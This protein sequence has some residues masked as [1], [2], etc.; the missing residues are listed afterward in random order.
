MSEY[1]V[2][3]FRAIDRPVTAENLEF[4]EEQSSRAEIT[5]WSFDNVYNYGDFRGDELEML[6]RGYDLFVHYANFGTRKVMIRLPQGLPDPQAAGPYF[7]ED[8]FY[9]VADET[10][11]GGSLCIEPYLEEPDDTGLYDELVGRLIP[12]R[13]EIVAGD[14]RP[15]YLAYLAAIGDS[16]HDWEESLEAPI[17]AGMGELTDAQAALAEFYDFSRSFLDVIAEG[18]PAPPDADDPTQAYAAWVQEQDTAI[19]DAWLVDLMANA[20]SL[21]RAEMLAEFREARGAVAWPT[22]RLERTMEELHARAEVLQQKADQKAAAKKLAAERKALEAEEL[23][24]AKRRGEISKAPERFLQQTEEL[25]AKRGKDSFREA[26]E[27]LADMRSAFA[28]TDRADLAARQAEK[29]RNT[30][31][32]LTHLIGALRREGF[33]PK[34]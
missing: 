12:L 16:N 7:V 30:H 29:L 20:A 19:K 11:R 31:P 8:A 25:V 5:P 14:L 15:L 22:V 6:R 34:K 21:V 33:L 3:A 4:M 13:D 32:T 26:A 17:P 24:R 2:V 18:S 28:G 10:G 1:Q 9:F 27:I 23:R